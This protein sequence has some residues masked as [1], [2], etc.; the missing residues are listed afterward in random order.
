MILLPHSCSAGITGERAITPSSVLYLINRVHSALHPTNHPA[1]I[2]LLPIQTHGQSTERLRLHLHFLLAWAVPITHWFTWGQR[3]N[4]SLEAV[5]RTSLEKSLPE[6]RL[7]LRAQS[8]RWLPGKPSGGQKHKHCCFQQFPGRRPGVL[9]PENG[10]GSPENH[11]ES[12]E[13]VRRNGDLGQA[14]GFC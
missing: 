10:T 11:P 8:V 2:C 4:R 13:E 5:C 3:A 1:E 7:V 9:P 6:F 12:W 14:T